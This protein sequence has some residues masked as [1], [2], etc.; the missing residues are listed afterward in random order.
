MRDRKKIQK[1]RCQILM[2]MKEIP[3]HRF[4][5]KGIEIR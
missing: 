3:K 4:K 1:E 2:D 5:I